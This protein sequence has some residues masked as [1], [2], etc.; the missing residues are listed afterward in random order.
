MVNTKKR[1]DEYLKL[2][3]NIQADR[4]RKFKHTPYEELNQLCWSWFNKSRSMNVPLSGP[5]I[6]ETARKLAFDLKLPSFKASNGWL[7][8]FIKSH[9]INLK[10]ALDEDAEDFEVYKNLNTICNTYVPGNIFAVDEISLSWKALPDR[11]S[12]NSR[13]RVTLLVGMNA[14]GEK[15]KGL[16]V[17]MRDTK[18]KLSDNLHFTY[19]CDKKSWLTEQIFTDWLQSCNEIFAKENRKVLF[20]L[21]SLHNE[22]SLSN[23][24]LHFL[25]LT[26][27]SPLQ[28]GIIK[29]LKNNY[30]CCLLRHLITSSHLHINHQISLNDLLLWLHHAYTTIDQ[31]TII[32]AFHQSGIISTTAVSSDIDAQLEN[33]IVQAQSTF[34]LKHKL[35]LDE[36]HQLDESNE[37][38]NQ[39]CRCIKHIIYVVLIE[40]Y[41]SYSI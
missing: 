10:V 7:Q 33:L 27:L 35:S 8:G 5:I 2:H 37:A 34:L 38:P 14:L 18:R 29:N 1:K 41:N 24:T 13:D 16:V 15:L 20:L 4:K 31:S 22:T 12:K 6:Q 26:I 3:S 36:Y 32:N 28:H 21:S 30:R 11:V 17:G 9:N 23:I 40:Y 39:V 25:P 19:C